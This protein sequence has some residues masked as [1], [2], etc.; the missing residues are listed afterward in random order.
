M[1]VT[2]GGTP[3]VESSDL[4]AN[5]PAVSLALAEHIDDLGKILQ[6]VRATDATYRTTTSTT[7]TDITGVTVTI[8][9]Q[10]ST[11]A[12]LL[13][14]TG[15][16]SNSGASGTEHRSRV[17]ITDASNNPISGAENPA[18]FDAGYNFTS[19]FTN[20]KTLVLIAYDT[21][22][23]TSA[24]TYKAQFQSIAATATTTLSGG[25]VTSQ[26]FAIEVSA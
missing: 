14:V 24:T 7:Y 3:Y 15:R 13:I 18:E 4:V 17:R 11:S 6:V 20:D 26:M 10:K 19:S 23:T 12:I 1:A 9:P 16:L 2:A 8:T 5:Y 21:P 22:A 25:T